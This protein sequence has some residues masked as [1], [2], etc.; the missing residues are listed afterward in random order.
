MKI[1]IV[2]EKQFIISAIDMRCPGLISVK[3]TLSYPELVEGLSV[4]NCAVFVTFA[5]L[6]TPL[7][8]STFETWLYRNHGR[9]QKKGML[10]NICAC[11][12]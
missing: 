4:Q 12:L 10:G 9:W 1:E 3:N 5:E 2:G 6:Q 11:S 7:K 8:P